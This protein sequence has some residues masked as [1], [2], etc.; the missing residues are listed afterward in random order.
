MLEFLLLIVRAIGLA[1]RGRRELVLENI[2][3]RHQLRI[4]QRSVKRPELRS[5]DRMFWVLLARA[6]RGWR[7]AL[8]VS[9]AKT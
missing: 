8:S 6:W 3:L 1:C 4:L 7:S 2:A 9:F 5:R